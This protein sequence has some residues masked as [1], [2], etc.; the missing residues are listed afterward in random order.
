M[1]KSIPVEGIIVDYSKRHDGYLVEVWTAQAGLGEAISKLS[2]RVS[3]EL[4]NRWRGQARGGRVKG[5]QITVSMSA[6]VEEEPGAPV[7]QA[8][9]VPDPAPKP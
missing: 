6:E 3:K 8:S 7:D 5:L 2:L 1:R 4:F 9:P